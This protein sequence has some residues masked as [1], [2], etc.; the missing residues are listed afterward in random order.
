MTLPAASPAPGMVRG[1]R[2]QH[3]VRHQVRL[4]INLTV[5]VRRQFMY[6]F[7]QVRCRRAAYRL[8]KVPTRQPR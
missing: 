4:D 6:L 8:R 5:R 3:R 7:R 2:T 1:Y